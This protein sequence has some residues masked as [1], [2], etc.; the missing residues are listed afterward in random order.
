MMAIFAVIWG[1]LMLTEQLS[2]HLLPATVREHTSSP[3]LISLILFLNPLFGVIAQPLVGIIGDRIWTP[4]GRR[5]FF[6]ITG[7]PIVGI[8]LWFIPDARFLWHIF[9]LAGSACHFFAIYLYVEP[10]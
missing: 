8:C 2:I 5:A 9:V 10:V 7:A 6:L 4:I 3:F 1:A